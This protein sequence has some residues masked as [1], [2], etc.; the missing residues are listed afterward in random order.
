VAAQPVAPEIEVSKAIGLSAQTRNMAS[1]ASLSRSRS[2][3]PLCS[4]SIGAAVAAFCDL[5]EAGA[6]YPPPAKCSWNVAVQMDCRA[7]LTEGPAARSS[8]CNIADPVGTTPAAKA[9]CRDLADSRP[10]AFGR[11]KVAA[12]L[13]LT[14]C[15]VTILTSGR[16]SSFD[17]VVH[18]K[19]GYIWAIRHQPSGPRPAPGCGKLSA[20][21]IC[22][23]LSRQRELAAYKSF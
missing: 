5:V 14:S 22:S 1:L 3:E 11:E 20:N 13:H 23:P 2:S 12:D 21:V 16:P 17:H 7:S 15:T 19:V 6:V 10:A 4:A 18:P 9:P 8:I